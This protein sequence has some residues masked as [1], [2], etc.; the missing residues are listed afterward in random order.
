MFGPCLQAEGCAPSL[1]HPYQILVDGL[2]A[3][4]A[5]GAIPPPARAGAEVA[6]WSSV[7]GLAALLVEGAL[8]LPPGARA[9]AIRGVSRTL[10]LGL[11]CDP[12]LLPPPGAPV[13]ADP[14]GA[15]G[16]A[17]SREGGAG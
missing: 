14:R 8:P 9:D 7:H 12:A 17:R 1:R 3:L 13:D 2:D 6:A 15:G 5:A 4:V 16:S 10:L 11:G